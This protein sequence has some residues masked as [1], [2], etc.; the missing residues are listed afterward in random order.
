M[1]DA[2][3]ATAKETQ[4]PS[5]WGRGAYELFIES[6]GVP[7][8]TGESYDGPGTA[9]VPAIRVEDLYMTSVSP[10]V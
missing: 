1:S 3:P 10:A 8:H 2:T 7:I 4:R 6:E 5:Y 9:L